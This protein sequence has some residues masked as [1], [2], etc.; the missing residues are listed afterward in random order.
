MKTSKRYYSR[1]RVNEL[2]RRG[3]K[4]PDALTYKELNRKM[5]TSLRNLENK[6]AEILYIE[7][8]KLWDKLM[9]PRT[10]K[11]EVQVLNH[12]TKMMDDY[13][14]SFTDMTLML[15]NVE[16]E[17]NRELSEKQKARQ[18]RLILSSTAAQTRSS[19][20]QGW[21]LDKPSKKAS[22]RSKKESFKG[23]QLSARHSVMTSDS[24]A[25]RNVLQSIDSYYE[26]IKSV[27]LRAIALRGENWLLSRI[28]M[29]SGGGGGSTTLDIIY[30]SDGAAIESNLQDVIY[31]FELDTLLE[32]LPESERPEMKEK[33]KEISSHLVGEEEEYN[34]NKKIDQAALAEAFLDFGNNNQAAFDAFDVF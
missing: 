20:D 31:F 1:A 7:T 19:T 30:S 3:Q 15:N 29:A 12:I 26:P 8:T 24:I 11:E 21:T 9:N 17:D 32:Q 14:Y 4:T 6:D 25:V 5:K 27:V 34:V 22:M 33:L 23:S 13:N 16:W 28:R 10:K 18:E 2:R